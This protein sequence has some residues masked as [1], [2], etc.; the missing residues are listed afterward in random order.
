MTAE[1]FDPETHADAVARTMGLVIRPEWKASVLAN[2]K[3]TATAAELVMSFP[4][5]D[6]VESAPVF[7]P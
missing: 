5:E 6:H 1:P 4:L 7:E 3:A 2:L